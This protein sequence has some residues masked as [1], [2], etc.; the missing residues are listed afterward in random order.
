ME[1]RK[2]PSRFIIGLQISRRGSGRQSLPD[3]A[4]PKAAK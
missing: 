2:A 3:G 1:S 4:T